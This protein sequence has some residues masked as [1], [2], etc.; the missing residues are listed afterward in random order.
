MEKNKL[1]PLVSIIIPVYNGANY[2]GEAIECALNQ[3]YKNIEIIVVNDGSNDDGATEK[4]AVSYG[5]RIKYFKKENG[6]VSSALNFGI[7]NMKGEYFSWLSHDDKYLPDKIKNSVELL[8]KYNF[9]E[10]LLAYTNSK[11]INEKSEYL[12][13][14]GVIRFA[15]EEIIEPEDCIKSMLKFGSLN[16]CALLIPKKAFSECGYFD[17][18]LRY[19]QDV[20]MWQRL[21]GKGYKIV[22]DS[23]FN[24]LTR[25][26]AN[27][28][29]QTRRDLLVSDSMAI[30][31]ELIKIFL[32]QKNSKELAVLY[33]ERTAKNNLSPVTKRSI[34][35]LKNN[36]I[37]NIPDIIK[38]YFFVFYGKFRKFLKKVYYKLVFKIKVK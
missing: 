16:G 35:I 13:K 33:C 21:F 18:K 32:S 22:A 25:L 2:L 8:S 24:A 20:L 4:I 1:N 28:V 9:D 26:H 14:N 30:N 34:Q 12:N 11:Y 6:G 38:I 15:T 31:D 17:E 3:T 5:D 23:S 19:C 10:K 29:T 36:K 7:K 27:Q 37:L